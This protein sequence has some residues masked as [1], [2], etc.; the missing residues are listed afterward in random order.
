M[1]DINTVIKEVS[2][3]VDKDVDLV[4]AVCKH[5]FIKTV[6]VMKD[7]AEARDILFNKLFKFKLKKRFKE[8]KSRP[9]TK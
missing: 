9:Y 7:P 4:A 2:L 8:D 3:E 5:P 1:F 6:E